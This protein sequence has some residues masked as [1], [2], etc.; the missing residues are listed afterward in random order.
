[1]EQQAGG[2]IVDSSAAAVG[3]VPQEKK[4]EGGGGLVRVESAPS[5]KRSSDGLPPDPKNEDLRKVSSSCN[6][7]GDDACAAAA[8]DSSSRGTIFP[9][10]HLVAGMIV[11]WL[12]CMSVGGLAKDCSDLLAETSPP[13]EH[14]ACMVCCRRNRFLSNGLLPTSTYFD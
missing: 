1:M 8:T 2:A 9:P 14:V 12:S 7:S 13:E 3:G 5:L 6:T 10:T 11:G 4:E